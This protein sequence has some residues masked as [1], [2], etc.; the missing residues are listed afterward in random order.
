MVK[1]CILTFQPG[2]SQARLCK[3]VCR[4]TNQPLK[5]FTD[6]FYHQI[7]NGIPGCT[8]RTPP[9]SRWGRVRTG[10]QT[11]SS[12]MPWPLDSAKAT[13]S[14][15]NLY[16]ICVLER[17]LQCRWAKWTSGWGSS[18]S[19]LSFLNW[20]VSMFTAAHPHLMTK[21]I[22]NLFICR[23]VDRVASKQIVVWN[24]ALRVFLKTFKVNNKTG[25]K[26]L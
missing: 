1:V 21:G 14:L 10:D 25:W 22:L 15:F 16:L 19:Q 23:R 5:S 4:C 13:S 17:L 3:P 2:G 7:R 11:I 24:F 8:T 9:L 26:R 20:S 12:P 18:A 6:V